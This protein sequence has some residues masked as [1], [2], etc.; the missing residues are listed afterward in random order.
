MHVGVERPRVTSG[1]QDRRPGDGAGVEA[2]RRPDAARGGRTPSQPTSSALL[3]NGAERRDEIG[4]VARLDGV[5]ERRAAGGER[6]ARQH[7]GSGLQVGAHRARAVGAFGEKSR[8]DHGHERRGEGVD[9]LARVM[10][11]EDERIPLDPRGGDLGEPRAGVPRTGACDRLGGGPRVEDAARGEANAMAERHAE[12]GAGR[13]GVGFGEGR[14]DLS[15]VSAGV[16]G[17]EERVAEQGGGRV[18]YAMWIDRSDGPRQCGAPVGRRRVFERAPRRSPDKARAR[19]LPPCIPLRARHASR[20]WRRS[21]RRRAHEPHFVS[22][23]RDEGRLP[24]V[25]RRAHG[26]RATPA[27]A[28][29]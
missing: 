5:Q 12:G 25:F 13:L 18:V 10:H 21:L 26:E 1:P 24:V 16:E 14:H 22:H 17:V 8:R 27:G 15:G 3:S 2:P 20:S 7:D 11:R 23:D 28:A 19:W 4:S 9:E 6:V 29:M